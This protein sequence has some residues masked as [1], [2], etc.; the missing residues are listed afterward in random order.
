VLDKDGLRVQSVAVPHGMM[1][2]VASR[3]EHG[4]K[5]IVFSGDVQSEYEP[6]VKLAAGCDL[7]V[8]DLA[9]PERVVAHEDH[10]QAGRL[11]ATT[12]IERTSHGQ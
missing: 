2:S 4:G 7:L 10:P 3:I 1:P 6:L 11:M 8:H 9:L 12:Q 5:S